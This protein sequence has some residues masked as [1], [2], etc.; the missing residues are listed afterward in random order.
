MITFFESAF[1]KILTS[2]KHEYEKVCEMSLGIVDI[3]S[4][5]VPLQ[6]VKHRLFHLLCKC[7]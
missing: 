7:Y 4:R 1:M 5:K 6:I 3:Y 2:E